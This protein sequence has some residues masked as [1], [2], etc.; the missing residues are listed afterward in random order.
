MTIV[1]QDVFTQEPESYE[2][3]QAFRRLRDILK[4][5][6]GIG[7][8]DGF[9]RNLD[10]EMVDVTFGLANIEQSISHSLRTV[11]VGYLVIRNDNGG[12]IYDGASGFSDTQIFLRSTVASTQ[13]RIFILR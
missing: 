3:V 11:P 13:A 7:T 4:G 12:V 9:E 6:V 8:I 10:G 5:R 2:I 1:E